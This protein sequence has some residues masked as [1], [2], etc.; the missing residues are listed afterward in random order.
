MDDWQLDAED[1]ERTV[2]ELTDANGRMLRFRFVAALEHGGASYV[3][4]AELEP[5]TEE[6]ELILMRVAS[7]PEGGEDH[8]VVISDELELDAVFGKYVACTF[9]D[10]LDG[11]EDMERMD[12]VDG[13]DCGGEC[14]CGHGHD[15]DEDCA[16]GGHSVLH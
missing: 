14:G 8:Y 5:E 10:A 13:C 12:G 3:V 2:V 4:L 6:D 15:S 9:G 11:L 16:C 7:D 1:L